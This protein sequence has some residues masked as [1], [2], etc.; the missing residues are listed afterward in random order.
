[1]ARITEVDIDSTSPVH[2]IITI[3]ISNVGLASS[4]YQTRI[5]DCPAG[6][7]LTW[8]NAK[9]VFQ[10]ISPQHDYTETID[11]HGQLPFDKFHCTGE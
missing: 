6:L 3:V 11:L 1:M 2:T 9:G 7:P 10:V 5:V 4:Y 8:T